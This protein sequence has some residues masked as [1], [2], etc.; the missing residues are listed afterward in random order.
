MSSHYLQMQIEE[1]TNHGL[2]MFAN[3]YV[4]FG[5]LLLG[6]VLVNILSFHTFMAPAQ[7]RSRL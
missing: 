2:F 1:E 5:L 3:R 4:P 7:I 6:P